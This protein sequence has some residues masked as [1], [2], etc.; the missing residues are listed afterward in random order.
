MKNTTPVT[1]AALGGALGVVVTWV[2]GPLV[3][4]DVPAT[5]GA[6]ISTICTAVVGLVY[7]P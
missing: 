2:L 1:A 7:S 3:G 5:V 4:L 6:A